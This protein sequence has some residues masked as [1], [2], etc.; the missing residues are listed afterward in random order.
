MSN[1]SNEERKIIIDEDWKSQVEREREELKSRK[2]EADEPASSAPGSEQIPEASFALLVTTLAT[3]AM[4]AMG[5][6]Q[7]PTQDKP[8]VHLG[9][10]RHHIDMLTVLEEKTKGNLDPDETAMLEQV[11]HQLRLLFVEVQKA[12]A[13]TEPEVGS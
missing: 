4:A 5:Q 1:E 7:D 3:Q 10:A 12:L 8:L 11:L 9:L 6:L 2:H 13:S